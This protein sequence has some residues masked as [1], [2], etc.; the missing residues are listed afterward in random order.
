V[1]VPVRTAV[2]TASTA[3][4]AAGADGAKIVAALQ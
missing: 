3:A 2:A 1:L 4:K